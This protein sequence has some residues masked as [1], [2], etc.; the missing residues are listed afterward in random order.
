VCLGL[1]A[2]FKQGGQVGPDQIRVMPGFRNG[3]SGLRFWRLI[4]LSG[5]LFQ[6]DRLSC[7]KVL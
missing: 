5:D 3:I 2:G 1:L 4:I 7:D 6:I